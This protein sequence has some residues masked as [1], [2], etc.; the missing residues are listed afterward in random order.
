MTQEPE[1]T[2]APVERVDVGVHGRVRGDGAVGEVESVLGEGHRVR[3][4]ASRRAGPGEGQRPRVLQAGR[5]ADRAHG[6]VGGSGGLDVE[7]RDVGGV[8]AVLR[9]VA[10]LSGP[11]RSEVLE[12]FRGFGL[13]D[14]LDESG[15]AEGGQDADDHDHDGQLDQGE[16]GAAAR[17][18][19]QSLHRNF[20]L[21]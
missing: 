3:P 14:R 19:V 10:F 13:L 11:D 12:G 2:A 20:L 21:N 16:P 1:T 4:V 5:V 8:G 9:L 6:E 18:D 15:D 7:E 17:S